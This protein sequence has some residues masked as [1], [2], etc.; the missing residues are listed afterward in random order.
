MNQLNLAAMNLVA[1][2]RFVNNVMKLD[3]VDVFPNIMAIHML[4]VDQN[5]SPIQNAHRIVLASIIFVVILVP[6]HVASLP[7]A[8]SLTMHHFV[9]ACMDTSVIH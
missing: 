7:F 8:I 3:R 9:V 2:T 4:N 6:E 1:L 5:V